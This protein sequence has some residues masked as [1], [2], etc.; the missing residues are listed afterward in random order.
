MSIDI[1]HLKPG[2][3]AALQHVA[4]DVFD[5]AI[6]P[7]RLTA[8]LTEPNHHMIVALKGSEV[9]GQIRAVV[10]KHPDITQ[11]LFVENLGVTPALQ[12]QGIA[13][14]LLGAML[15]LGKKLGCDEAWLATEANNAPARGLYESFSVEAEAVVMYTFKL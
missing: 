4:R 12:R 1:R 15:K 13:T 6:D 11:Q 7:D 9:V 8:Y 5:D 2:D 14:K 3:E 10:L